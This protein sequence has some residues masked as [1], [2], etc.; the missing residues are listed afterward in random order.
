MQCNDRRLVAHE[1]EGRRGEDQGEEEEG[2]F[3][4]GLL[5][6]MTMTL[7][8]ASLADIILEGGR[9]FM[10]GHVLIAIPLRK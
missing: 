1:A 10:H 7:T 6:L 5:C 9:I 3:G 4:R 8:T 2:G